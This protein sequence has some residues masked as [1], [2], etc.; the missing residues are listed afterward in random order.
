MSL[1]GNLKMPDYRKTVWAFLPPR[2]APLALGNKTF[3]AYVPS[4]S[5]LIAACGDSFSSLV[6]QSTPLM[7][8]RWLAC[9]DSLQPVAG[10]TAVE[11]VARLWLAFNEA[12]P[13]AS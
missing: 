10:A 12:K 1:P 7:G 3:D 8:V 13:A 2:I 4:L 6:R 9:S 5:E 11:A